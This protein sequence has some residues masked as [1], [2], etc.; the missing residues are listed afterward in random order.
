MLSLLIP[1]YNY[2]CVKLVTDLHTQA[3]KLNIEY[4]ILVA[5][6]HSEENILIQNREIGKLTNC[7]YL[8][9]PRNVGRAAIRNYL[10]DQAKYDFLL[11]MDSD[12]IVT[13]ADFLKRYMA[14]I[15]DCEVVCG[16]IIHPNTLPSTAVSLRY[17]YEKEAEKRF[18]AERRRKNAYGEF[19]SFN[20]LIRKDIFLRHRFDEAIRKYGF[21][22]TLLGKELMKDG[23]CVTHIDN[24]LMNGDIE[25]NA[26]Y[27]RKIDESLQT[28]FRFQKQL[29]GFSNIILLRDILNKIH[30]DQVAACLFSRYEQ[31]IRKNLLSATP[32]LLFLKFYKIGKYCCISLQND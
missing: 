4:E 11:F 27:L 3:E 32:S 9:L 13:D 10:A 14:C 2:N 23:V 30:M 29:K 1:T 15:P 16:G 8:E 12:A 20:F 31:K 26:T 19:R 24:P 7:R 5:D 22:D 6:D 17:Y 18:T 28:L 25:D 21:E